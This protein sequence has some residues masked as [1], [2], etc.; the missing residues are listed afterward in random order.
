VLLAAVLAAAKVADGAEAAPPHQSLRL[1]SSTLT[2]TRRIN[3]YL[4]PGYDLCRKARYPVLYLPDGGMEEDFPH[5]ATA[6]ERLIRQGFARPFLIVGIE[7]TVRRRD[8]TGPTTSPEDREV[9]RQPGGAPRFRRFI[10]YELVPWVRARYRVTDESAIMGESL[11]GLFVVDTLLNEPRLFNTYIAL[12][13]SLW[14][15]AEGLIRDAPS[16]LPKLHS[17]FVRLFMSSGGQESNL[18]EVAK[19]VA[20]LKQYAP[21]SV[22]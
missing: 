2:E 20:A 22:L 14:W 21:P 11:A 16:K 6:A 7:N 13:P 3:I 1:E 9:T 10:R 8:M 4:P 18:I 17:R 5:V 19:M 15:N 12:D